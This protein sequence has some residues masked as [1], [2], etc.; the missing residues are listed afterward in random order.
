MSDDNVLRDK[1]RE[2]VRQLPII[3]ENIL[4]VAAEQPLWFLQA[5]RFRVTMMRR[6]AAADA[7]LEQFYVERG[8]KMRE[9]YS[10]NKVTESFIK[11]HVM[12]SEKYRVLKDDVKDAEASEEFSK[13][14]L[15][16]YRMRRDA[17]KIIAEADHAETGR[18]GV[19]LARS[20]ADKQLRKETRRLLKHQ[21]RQEGE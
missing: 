8:L 2:L 10:E 17:I 1:L 21:E 3:D 7:A 6:H 11:S 15:E 20:R 4:A 19:E 16:A 18:A 13:L 14:L 5:A 9:K 12:G